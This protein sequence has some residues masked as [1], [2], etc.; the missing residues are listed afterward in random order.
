MSKIPNNKDILQ[1]A[2]S[3][4]EKDFRYF[5]VNR[6]PLLAEFK[7]GSWKNLF[8]QMIYY[9][10]K[11]QE[12]FGIRYIPTKGYNPK[13]FYI[14]NVTKNKKHDKGDMEHLYDLAIKYA[15]EGGNDEIVRLISHEYLLH[16]DYFEREWEKL[17]HHHSF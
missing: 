9:I 8:V 5:I 15:E 10:S 12:D 17:S 16:D 14:D 7:E 4:N 2:E 11:L 13:T 1:N 6:Y 3:Y